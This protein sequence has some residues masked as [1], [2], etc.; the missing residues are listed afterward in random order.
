M[1]PRG[2]ISEAGLRFIK[3]LGVN[4]VGISASWVPGYKG[5]G[6][7]DLDSLLSVKDQVE[8]FDLH[9]G[10]VYLGKLDTTNLLL[11]TPGRKRIWTMFVGPL[12]AWEGLPFRY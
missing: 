5:K 10:S 8:Q 12:I 4:D 7:I 2:G 6:H 3:Q 1:Y 11:D 9:L